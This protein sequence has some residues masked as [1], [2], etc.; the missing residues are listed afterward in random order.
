MSS[1]KI[2]PAALTWP[3]PDYNGRGIVVD[4]LQEFYHL[5]A[6]RPV[7]DYCERCL[8]QGHC[9]VCGSEALRD[10][11]SQLFNVCPKCGHD[12]ERVG[13]AIEVEVFEKAS[14]ARRLSSAI[15]PG[16]G[17]LILRYL[18]TDGLFVEFKTLG[19]LLCYKR[20]YWPKQALTEA[21]QV[22][23]EAFDDEPHSRFSHW[24]SEEMFETLRIALNDIDSLKRAA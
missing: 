11:E 22:M 1:V 21:A 19:D 3:C 14:G 2:I 16:A 20:S 9:P 8:M 7:E 12:V 17:R 4:R 6:G 24:L 10:E 23:I 15:D 13:G 18:M 5:R